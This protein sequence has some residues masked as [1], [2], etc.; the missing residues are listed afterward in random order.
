MPGEW[1]Y[2]R[3]LRCTLVFLDPRPTREDVG[4]AYAV[5]PTHTSVELPDSL[6]RRLRSYVRGG[7]L[8]NKF[9]YGE[10]ADRLQRLAGWLVHL[11]PGQREYMNRS[12]MYLPASCRGRVLDVGSGA[13]GVLEELRRLGWEDPEAA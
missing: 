3:C 12:I 2:K 11:H 6:P 4:K 5:Y 10:G 1:T 8:A 7:Y 13:G 9:G